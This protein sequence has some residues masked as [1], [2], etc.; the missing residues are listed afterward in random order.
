LTHRPRTA[1]VAGLEDT[2]VGL[3]R[4]APDGVQDRELAAP[5]TP[6]FFSPGVKE[7]PPCRAVRSHVSARVDPERMA[8]A[9]QT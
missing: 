4:L 9:K 8:S 6:A 5:C 7:F 3:C 1:Y 2:R